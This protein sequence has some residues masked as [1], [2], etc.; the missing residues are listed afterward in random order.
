[1]SLIPIADC[2]SRTP[3]A[4]SP[5]VALLPP[6]CPE[7]RE[8]TLHDDDFEAQ[9]NHVGGCLRGVL[10]ALVFQAAVLSLCLLVFNVW[11]MSR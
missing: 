2:A 10:L 5:R 6:E 7:Q 3:E 8:I 4:L 1:M 9:T 11:R